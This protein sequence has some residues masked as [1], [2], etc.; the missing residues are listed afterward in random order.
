MTLPLPT[1]GDKEP[2]WTKARLWVDRPSRFWND[3]R[4]KCIQ[5]FKSFLTVNLLSVDGEKEW[6]HS[7]LFEFFE[8]LLPFFSNSCRQLSVSRAGIDYQNVMDFRQLQPY[9]T[10]EGR[11]LEIAR[12]LKADILGRQIDGTTFTPPV[13]HR[14]SYSYA[15]SQADS[16]VS[17]SKLMVQILL[18]SQ[19]EPGAWHLDVLLSAEGEFPGFGADSVRKF[20]S[21]MHDIVSKG[22]QSTFSDEI[23][24][25]VRS[26]Q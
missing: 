19:K 2:D 18:P 23:V 9:T 14:F 10:A 6:T 26:L 20:L 13:I 12:V 7:D 22:F 11:T 17:P 24:Y 15:P 3:R 1:F 16:G 8:A 25:S 21:D 5:F 4:T